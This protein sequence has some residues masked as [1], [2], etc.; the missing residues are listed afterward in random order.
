VRPCRKLNRRGLK[1]RNAIH[2]WHDHVHNLHLY[3]ELEAATWI[4]RKEG[5]HFARIGKSGSEENVTGVAIGQAMPHP[6]QT[7]DPSTSRGTNYTGRN[8][9]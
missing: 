1:I 5:L 7:M 3:S 6:S 8:R 9:S 4:M 2:L